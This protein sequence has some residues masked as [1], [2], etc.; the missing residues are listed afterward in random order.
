MIV[1]WQTLTSRIEASKVKQVTCE[2]CGTAYY[3]EMTRQGIGRGTALYGIGTGRAGAGA[4]RRAQEDLNRRL[5]IESDMV[6]CPKCHWVSTDL[7]KTY[8][9]GRYRKIGRLILWVFIGSNFFLMPVLGMALSKALGYDSQLER[10]LGMAI[11]VLTLGSPIWILLGRSVL[12]SRINPNKRYPEAPILP[13]GTPEA[14]VM[15]K[16]EQTGEP[17]LVPAEGKNRLR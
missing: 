13:K 2:R 9:K 16:D 10:V 5:E 8:R 7:I 14:L 11:V 15:A 6:P 1:S 17:L 4:E 12:R 3:Y